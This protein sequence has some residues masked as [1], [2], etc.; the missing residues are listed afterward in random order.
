MRRF[1][2]CTLLVGTLSLVPGAADAA[3]PG[4]NGRIAYY[5]Y[6]R[7]PQSIHTIEPDGTGDVKLLE[8]RKAQFEPNWS[9]DGSRIVFMR[10]GGSGFQSIV[11]TAADGTDL[12]VI[13]GNTVLP[14]FSGQPVW[15]PDASMVAFCAWG[16]D[17]RQKIFVVGADGT[18]LT[19]ISGPGR[20]DCRPA[21]SPDGSRIAVDSGSI[22]SGDAVIVTMDPDGTDRTTVVG[23]GDNIWPDWSPEG[24][25]LAFLKS[26]NHNRDIFVVDAGGGTPTRLTA[27]PGFEWV[28]S[29]APDGTGIVYC[30]SRTALSPCDLFTMAPDGTDVVRVTDTPRRDEF[31][32]DWQ[33]LP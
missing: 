15:S 3:F 25:Q 10:Y 29:W 7:S 23:V 33:P 1:A 22:A 18:G 19:N 16:H 27:T 14:R 30:R 4:T 11:S 8:D 17:D 32:P 9:A 2:I 31:Y 6:N 28:P 5:V 26:I 24:T 13:A 21:W 20:D 12:Q